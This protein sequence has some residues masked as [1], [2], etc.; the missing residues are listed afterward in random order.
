VDFH[1]QHVGKSVFF[2][3]RA[4]EDYFRIMARFGITLAILGDYE[5]SSQT[6]IQ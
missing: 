5:A 4:R 6:S 1:V 2:S 3:G